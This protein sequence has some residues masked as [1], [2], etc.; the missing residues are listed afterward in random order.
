MGFKSFR[1]LF[2]DIRAINL[3]AMIGPVRDHDLDPVP[4]QHGGDWG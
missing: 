4:D 3:A 2:S 1:Q